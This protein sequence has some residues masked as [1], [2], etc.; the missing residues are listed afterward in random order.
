MATTSPVVLPA[1]PKDGV[2]CLS[3]DSVGEKGASN[4]GVRA[5][6][7]GSALRRQKGGVAKFWV[8]QDPYRAAADALIRVE[9]VE[10]TTVAYYVR[11]KAA[12][13]TPLND[14]GSSARDPIYPGSILLPPDGHVRITVTIG[15]ASAC[16]EVTM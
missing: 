7:L 5:G 10:S 8:A 9:H 15:K 16:F 3:G 6:P 14:D 4:G 13:V 12:I 1:T 11:D 2:P